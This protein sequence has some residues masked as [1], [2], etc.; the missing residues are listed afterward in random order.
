MVD[1]AEIWLTVL[2]QM[3]SK[4]DQWNTIELQEARINWALEHSYSKQVDQIEDL[5]N[6]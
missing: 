2:E 1:D 6:D 5:L 4:I 3:I